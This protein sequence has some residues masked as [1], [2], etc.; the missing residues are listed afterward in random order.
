MLEHQHMDT[1]SVSHFGEMTQIFYKSIIYIWFSPSKQTQR[2]RIKL[3]KIV[4][5]VHRWEL[6][7]VADQ[8]ATRESENRKGIESN[9]DI[10]AIRRHVKEIEESSAFKGSLRSKRFLE[11]VVEKAIAGDS[12]AL[13]ERLIGA[14]L[15][16]R[17]PSYNT[18]DD[19]IVRVTASHVRKR[20]LRYYATYGETSKFHLSLPPGSYHP[21]ITCCSSDGAR[22]HNGADVEEKSTGASE[23]RIVLQ[24]V[25]S[26]VW[27]VRTEGVP[28]PV[29]SN[30]RTEPS[31]EGKSGKRWLPG[32]C[33][34]LIALNLMLW[35][36]FSVRFAGKT[37]SA[38]V[39]PW[40]AFFSAPRSTI[41]VTSD[42]DIAE[43]ESLTGNHLIS[44]SDYANHHYVPEPNTLTPEVDKICRDALIGNKSATVDVPIA[45]NITR[46]AQASSREIDVRPARRVQ[47]S[48]LYTNNNFI[49]LGSPRSN[50]WV[51]LFNNQLDFR[52]FNLGGVGQHD[53]IVNV[54]PRGREARTYIPTAVHG[55]TGQTYAIVAFVSS[56]NHVGQ[57]LLIAG[58]DGEGTE[59]AGKFIVDL[60]L[61]STTLQ[62]CGISPTGPIRH[63]ELLL[64]LNTIATS[65]TS[66][67]VVAC[68]I[69]PDA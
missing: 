30:L 43:I 2:A 38:S 3:R 57:V 47:L 52:F 61:L 63:F 41:L 39:L 31:S 53:M 24:Q 58:A 1:S 17:S 8:N 49:F 10:D 14:E 12:E 11:H 16:G 7:N 68:H 4:Y 19:S 66:M 60:P 20:L 67:N 37:A 26:P 34:L 65:P 69:L 40:S 32:F 22:L 48:E 50:P 62:K 33:V 18:G 54:H 45:A 42:P 15:F 56:L 51:Y 64:G 13:K 23:E 9:E 35:G 25:T 36:A 21:E 46:L 27:Q 44:V 5:T 28:V 6:F 29:P 59:A 55:V